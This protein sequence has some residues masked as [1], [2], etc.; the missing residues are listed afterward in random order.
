MSE[1][2]F[3]EYEDVMKRKKIQNLT[4]LSQLGENELF[5]ACLSTCK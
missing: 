5:E 2:R 1:A 3:R 4:P